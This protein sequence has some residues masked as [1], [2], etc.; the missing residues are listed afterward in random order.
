VLHRLSAELLPPCIE[1]IT[2]SDLPNIW[3]PRPDQFYQVE[4][5]PYLGTGK[6]DLRGV[7]NVA[8]KLSLE[9]PA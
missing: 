3:K 1:K 5:F 6:L 7:K 2:Q 9:K 4:K 8:E